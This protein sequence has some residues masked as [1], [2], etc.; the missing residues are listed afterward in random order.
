MRPRRLA[1]Q[2]GSVA[3][4]DQLHSKDKMA[5]YGHQCYGGSCHRRYLRVVDRVINFNNS[6]I[7]RFFLIV[8]DQ[9]SAKFVGGHG[10]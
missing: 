6:A 10:S 5:R 3:A 7:V 2:E 1:S 8:R 9:V 4:A